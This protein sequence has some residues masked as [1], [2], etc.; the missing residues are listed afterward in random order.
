MSVVLCNTSQPASAVIFLLL[1]GQIKW[2]LGQF[3]TW[4]QFDTY[5]KGDYHL[6][7]NFVETELP[8]STAGDSSPSSF[9]FSSSPNTSSRLL[10][11][12]IADAT[13]WTLQ[14][15]HRTKQ[16]RIGSSEASRSGLLNIKPDRSCNSKSSNLTCW[17]KY[18]FCK[19]INK[20]LNIFWLPLLSKGFSVKIDQ[21]DTEKFW[22]LGDFC[23][24][25]G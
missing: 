12:P 16:V 22:K 15:H 8:A 11:P 20:P 7:S 24:K 3:D 10:P 2:F 6:P 5:T 9:P 23:A 18:Y 21:V 19:Q 4:P 14:C 17:L 25:S 13:F 1:L